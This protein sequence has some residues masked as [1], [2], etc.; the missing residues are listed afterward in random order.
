MKIECEFHF[1][2]EKPHPDKPENLRGDHTFCYVNRK[3]YGLCTLA[4]NHY[5]NVWDGPDGDDFECKTDEV[6]SWMALPD[7]FPEKQA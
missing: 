6:I 2:E 1:T 7:S 3:R 4:W 5:H